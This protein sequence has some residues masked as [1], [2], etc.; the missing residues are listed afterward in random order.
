MYQLAP[1]KNITNDAQVVTVLRAGTTQGIL[2]ME[3]IRLT[4][5]DVKHPEN[6][7]P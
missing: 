3:E 5:W 1:E 7:G 6:N 4:T 2:L